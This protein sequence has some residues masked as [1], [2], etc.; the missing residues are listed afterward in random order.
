M[1]QQSSIEWTDATWNP[2][3]GCSK[4]SPGCKHCYAERFAERWRGIPGHPYER[5]FD[6]RLV[7]EHLLDPLGWSARRVIF[8]NSMSDLFHEAVPLS[9]IRLVFEAMAAADWHVFQVLTK[10]AE[11]MRE[12]LSLLPEHLVELPHVWLGVSVEDVAH[13]VPRIGP[14]Q[15]SKSSIRFLSVEPLLENLGTLDLDRIDWMI[16]GGE[17]GPGARPMEEEWVL[18]LRR[19]ARSSGIPFFFKQWGG[20][21][22][23][24]SGRELRGEEHNEM[25]AMS[26]YDLPPRLVRRERT[27]RLRARLA[28]VQ[29]EEV[30]AG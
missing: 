15:E 27:V 21:W 9:Y 13:G 1:A 14:L 7:P 26:P 12:A 3:R 4:V 19:Q 23:H 16:V 30:T 2:V 24:K 22:K 20:V 18:D 6:P 10:R 17:S 28:S 29:M 5:G 8:V 25:P 11:R